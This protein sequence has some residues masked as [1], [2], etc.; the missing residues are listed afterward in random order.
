LIES[1]KVIQPEPEVIQP[2]PEVRQLGC[3]KDIEQRLVELESKISE[4]KLLL[5][6]NEVVSL[7]ENQKSNGLG[8]IRTGDLRHVKATS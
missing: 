7:H 1:K 5:L 8:R 3:Q 2:E 4:L 6:L